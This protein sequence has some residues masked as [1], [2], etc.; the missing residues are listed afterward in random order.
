[1][2]GVINKTLPLPPPDALMMPSLRPTER[3]PEIGVEEEFV[4]MNG[5]EGVQSD[6]TSTNTGVS[7]R[8]VVLVS[9]FSSFG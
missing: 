2:R 6:D 3:T 1:M 8:E 4:N 9:A 7:V 5:A